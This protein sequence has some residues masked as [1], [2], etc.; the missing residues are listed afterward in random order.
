M[1][2][3]LLAQVKYQ[4]TPEHFR[5]S[6]RGYLQLGDVRGAAWVDNDLPRL[7]IVERRWADGNEHALKANDVERVRT[8]RP[9]P[10]GMVER[11]YLGL[12]AS[13]DGRFD[14][15]AHKHHDSCIT[16]VRM[17]GDTRPL[18]LAIDG[19]AA[20]AIEEQRWEEDGVKLAA[21]VAAHREAVGLPRS[22]AEAEVLDHRLRRAREH[23]SASDLAASEAAG[24]FLPLDETV[25]IARRR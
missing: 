23:L 18:L 12:V 4:D 14:G 2:S 24:M 6:V 21:A 13:H 25:L 17:L 15:H 5:R 22:V 1:A 9:G 10:R 19:F 8:R 20:L 3:W 11:H 16:T 7:A